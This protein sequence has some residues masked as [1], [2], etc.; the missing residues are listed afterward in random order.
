MCNLPSVRRSALGLSALLGLLFVPPVRAEI[1]QIDATISAEVQEFISREEGSFD[2]AFEEFGATSA[3]LP[4]H[5]AAQLLPPEDAPTNGFT[6]A[7]FADF[8]D[9]KASPIPNPAEVGLETHVYSREPETNFA[10]HAI[11]TEKRKVSLSAEELGLLEGETERPVLSSVFVSGAVVIWSADPARDLT[12]LSVS[13]EIT[14]E[15]QLPD[16]DPQAV[17]H[18]LL[19]AAGGPDGTITLDSPDAIFA[20]LGGPELIHAA[21]GFTEAELLDELAALGQVYLVIIPRQELGYFYSAAEDTEFDLEATF[22]ARAVN[23]PGDTGIGAVYGRSFEALAQAIS[24]SVADATKGAATQ[25]AMNLAMEKARAPA[26]VEPG[27]APR[28]ATNSGAC[29]ALG[30][31]MLAMTFALLLA[32]VGTRRWD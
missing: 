11:A 18:A 23:L 32:A 7:A 13:L 9:P 21:A 29:G 2:S 22:E 4:I 3:T 8:R 26:R 17:F 6:A 1:R 28:A 15:Q 31:G 24:A 10:G 20:L 27:D 16:A 30:A 14:V 12:G 19:T 5:V 25:A